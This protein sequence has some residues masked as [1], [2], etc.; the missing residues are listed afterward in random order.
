LKEVE[1]LKAEN[2]NNQG[3]LFSLRH[4]QLS[5]SEIANRLYGRFNIEIRSGLHCAPLA[6]KFLGDFPA[7]AAR[8]A[9][10]PYHTN[11]DLKNLGIAIKEV[12]KS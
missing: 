5:A 11:E 12:L 3:A 10:S 4:E 9:F 6:H 1:L 8:F 7:G 2:F